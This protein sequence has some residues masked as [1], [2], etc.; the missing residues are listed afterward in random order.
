VTLINNGNGPDIPENTQSEVQPDGGPWLF[1]LSGLGGEQRLFRDVP[2][3]VPIEYMLWPEFFEQGNDYGAQFREVKA[4]INARRKGPVRMVGYSV[5][6][7]LAWACASAFQASGLGV[8][9]VIILDASAHPDKTVPAPRAARLRRRFEEL[10]AFTVRAAI[11]SLVAKFLSKNS[12][13]SLLRRALPYRNTALPFDFHSYLNHKLNMQLQLPVI[14]PWWKQVTETLPKLNAPVFLFRS[15]EHE[16]S[17]R[18]DLGW[19]ELCSDVTVV[20]VAGSHNG[21]LEP[22]NCQALSES[23][24]RVLQNTGTLAKS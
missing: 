8:E 24:L 3:V 20:P 1:L 6:G 17:E 5:G 4:Q 23:I 21:M 16:P 19:G 10:R 12:S 18:Q 7:M 2:Q 9:S 14:L 22:E 15:E 13:A 11:A